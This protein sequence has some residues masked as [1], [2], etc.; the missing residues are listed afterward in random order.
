MVKGMDFIQ[1][2]Q[3]MVLL[4]NLEVF[5]MIAICQVHVMNI[6]VHKVKIVSQIYGIGIVE[7]IFCIFMIV[8]DGQ[9]K[10]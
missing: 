5:L 10:Y 2:K 7:D 9:M 1:H 3:Y 8:G 4:D 6:F